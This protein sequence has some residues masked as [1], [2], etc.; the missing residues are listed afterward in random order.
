MATCSV[1][2]NSPGEGPKRFSAEAA[3][4]DVNDSNPT[5]A[6]TMK[7]NDSETVYTSL[8]PGVTGAALKNA[9]AGFFPGYF[10]VGSD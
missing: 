1:Y 3:M 7:W 2:S 5:W 8:T 9:F 4:A 10:V 6:V